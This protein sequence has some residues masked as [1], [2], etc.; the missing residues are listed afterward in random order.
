MKSW[1]WYVLPVGA[2][3]VLLG[4]AYIWYADLRYENAPAARFL[5]LDGTKPRL[6][7][8]RGSPVLVAFWATKCE[9]CLREMPELV[10][11]YNDFATRGLHIIGIAMP[12]EPPDLVYQFQTVH[13]LPYS[14]SL[15]IDARLASAFGDVRLTPTTFLV[16]PQGKIVYKKVGPFDVEWLRERIAGML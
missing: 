5:M 15:D 11:M 12:Y 16:S 3:L 14:L 7:D 8:L 13:K 10:R 1:R 9:E 2:V 4:L 6:S